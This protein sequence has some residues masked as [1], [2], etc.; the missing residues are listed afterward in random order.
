MR[1]GPRVLRQETG[2][3]NLWRSAD[4]VEQVAC[5]RHV[6]HLFAH[7]GADDLSHFNILARLD[8]IKRIQVGRN[9]G[10]FQFDS[11]LN[12]MAQAF[13]RSVE[14]VEQRVLKNNHCASKHRCLL[15]PARDHLW[16]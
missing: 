2:R 3:V 16:A 12:R 10:V 9:R 13:Y 14:S 1:Q 7:H 6:K 4:R 15:S 11:R 5:N 8:G